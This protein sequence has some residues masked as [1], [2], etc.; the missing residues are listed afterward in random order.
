MNSSVDLS[1][2]YA[3]SGVAEVLDQLERELVGLKPVK[4]RI[5]EIA[6]LLLVDRARKSM[7]LSSKMPGFDS[8]T[9]DISPTKRASASL[10]TLSRLV[11]N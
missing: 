9:L 4:T 8:L 6:A 5:K 10:R 2:A 3:D 1:D 11:N 7:D